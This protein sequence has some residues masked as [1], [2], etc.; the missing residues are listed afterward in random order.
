MEVPALKGRMGSVDYFVI[1]LP[2]GVA[3]R[4]ITTTDPN[5]PPQ[6]RENRKPSPARYREIAL[7]IR[8]NPD[9]YR[10]SAIT[11]T[12]GK[13]GTSA[14]VRWEPAQPDGLA[15]TIGTLTLDQTDPLVIVDGQHRFGA[16]KE[17][18]NEEPSLRNE[19]IT[20]VLFPY[21]SVG[22]AQQLFSDLNRT[23][24]KTTKSLDILFDNRDAVN[25]V[26][27]QL[28]QRVRTFVDRVNLE[29]ASVPTNSNQMFTLAAVYQATKP[30]IEGA[31]AAGLLPRSIDSANEAQ[32]VDCLVDVWEFV[33]E[34]FPEWGQVASGEMDIRMHRT[35]FLHWNSGVLSAMGEFIGE[36][37]RRSPQGWRGIVERAL[38]HPENHGWRRDPDTWQGIATAGT[39]VL[40][41]SLVTAQLRVYLKARAGLPLGEG[42]QRQLE[43]FPESTR[44]SL[45][46]VGA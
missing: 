30:M 25:R 27:Q 43:S 26:V 16:I 38:S 45:S 21:L 31:K 6:Q 42:E 36:A 8:H 13:E 15:S 3:E 33:S 39:Q 46:E 5:L 32:F 14:P 20:V 10:F 17:V 29:D 9:D 18:I 44:D 23:A 1:T 24:K 41:R 40:P 35:E 11:C 4:Y 28:V 19:V 34:Q 37:M 12:Y 2:F 22:A 7:Y